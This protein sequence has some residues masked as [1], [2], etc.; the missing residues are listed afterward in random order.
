MNI[1]S[2][3]SR[4]PAGSP[5]GYA[6]A[7]AALTSFGK[8]LSEEVAPRGVRVNTVSPGLTASPLWTDPERFGGTVAA[9]TGI[10]HA[11]LIAALP[12]QFGVASG[13]FS[14]SEEVAD[15]VA[16]LLSGRA[17]NIHG[18][19]YVIDGGTLKAPDPRALIVESGS[20][21]PDP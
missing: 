17:G 14:E 18:A 4:I 8:R 6:E 2:I 1:S 16:F 7:K 21:S 19:D 10:D 11:D 5:A 15:L 20:P 13:R 9:A 3:N 12:G